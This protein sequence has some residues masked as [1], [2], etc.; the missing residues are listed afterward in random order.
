MAVMSRRIRLVGVALG[1]AAALWVAPALPAAGAVPVTA[2]TAAAAPSTPVCAIQGSGP[3]SPLA[4]QEVTTSGVVTSVAD[5]GVWIQHPE[6]DGDPVTSDGLFAF[7]SDGEVGDRVEVSGEVTEFFG[8]TEVVADDTAVIGQE[9]V[10]S[11]TVIDPV[12][13]RDP[14]YYET[15]EGMLV[16][17]A[18][19]QTYVG[20]NKFGET[21]LIPGSIDERVRRTDTAPQLL[22]LD[23]ALPGVD[24]VNAFAFDIVEGATGPLSFSFENYKLLVTEP[25]EVHRGDGDRPAPI[26]AAPEG[27][28]SVAT[29]N[30]LNVF[31]EV[32]DGG[33]ATPEPS[34]AEQATKRAKIARGI[35]DQLRA[36]AVIAVQEVEK[37][38]LLQE[39]A[40]EIDRYAAEQGRETRYRAVLREGN[41]VR[42]I[43]VG[44][45]LDRSRVEVGAVRHLGAD[46]VSSGTCEGGASGNLVYDRV[47][48]AVDVRPTGA[49][50]AAGFTVVSNHFKSKFGGTPENDFFEDCRVEQA[51]VLRDNVSTL[52]RVMLLG[53]FNAFRD[54]RTV[55]ALTENGYA[56][57]VDEI[58]A[59]R[60][61]SF[62]FQGRVQF[63]DHVI[64]SPALRRRVEAVDSSKL[65]SD[66][67]FPR[68][69]NDPGTGFATSDH[70][71]LIAHLRQPG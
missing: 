2:G 37:L 31:D 47:P 5:D 57:T 10:P 12:A 9:P 28:L 61:F 63:L 62:V 4:G 58:P 48:L 41:D 42:G 26:V 67:P 66:T 15:L 51:Q 64:V 65:D 11:P 21:F 7:H 54:S 1:V 60:R 18:R 34:P 45:L 6:C 30:L 43:D 16:A 33:P 40:A 22:A 46:A 32:D 29:W 19:G 59:D 39:I 36:P 69:E 71:P 23:D 44:F 53:D 55:A 3:E 27:T 52:P 35:V 24:P 13:A 20:T 70:D 17:L 56:N 50:P 38:P 68:F 25:P 49:P 8:L 14:D